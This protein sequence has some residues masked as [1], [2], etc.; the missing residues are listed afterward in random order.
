MLR[1]VCQ[2]CAV[3]RWH[4]T[5]RFLKQMVH[6]QLFVGV[7][8]NNPKFFVVFGGSVLHDTTETQDAKC[9]LFE[10]GLRFIPHPSLHRQRNSCHGY[11]LREIFVVNLTPFRTVKNGIVAYVPFQQG[12]VPRGC[13][14]HLTV[15]YQNRFSVATLLPLPKLQ[16]KMSGALR[17]RCT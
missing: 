13:W 8:K 11:K 16:D 7:K 1:T 2:T 3:L 6:L 14:R 4:P 5:V 17:V 12:F 9:N 10:H 15:Q